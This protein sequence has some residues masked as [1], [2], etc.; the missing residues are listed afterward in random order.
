MATALLVAGITLLLIV[1]KKLLDYRKAVKSIQCVPSILL[2]SLWLR[3]IKFMVTR[4]HPG[5]RTV[6][7]AFGV[8]N[9]L[10]FRAPISGVS[11]GS[12]RNWK[13]KHAD[14]EYFGVDII[15]QV[16]HFNEATGRLGTRL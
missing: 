10:V 7:S 4:D 14:F 3:V 5:F 6:F 8:L 16:S 11:L 2:T 1:L 15:S 9:Q 12:F 13:T